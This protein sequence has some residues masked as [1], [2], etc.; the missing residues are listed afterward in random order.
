MSVHT[1]TLVLKDEFSIGKKQ[2]PSTLM[3]CDIEQGQTNLL[4]RVHLNH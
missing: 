1:G 4:D 3:L 2:Q